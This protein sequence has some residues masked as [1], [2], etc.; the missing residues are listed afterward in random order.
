LLLDSLKYFMWKLELKN[1]KIYMDWA[2]I[3]YGIRFLLQEDYFLLCCP[4]WSQV[5]DLLVSISWVAGR[6]FFK[7]KAFIVY[8]LKHR[9]AKRIKITSCI[10]PS[11]VILSSKSNCLVIFY[12]YSWKHTII[13]W[14]KYTQF[15]QVY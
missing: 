6:F 1:Q 7:H 15:I 5:H 3:L 14:N 13:Q 4:G 12:S 9:K 2:L 11:L 8:F 10:I